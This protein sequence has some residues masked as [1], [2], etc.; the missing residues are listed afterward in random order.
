M[1]TCWNCGATEREGLE[2][3][4]N[5]SRNNHSEAARILGI[6]RTTLLK[7]M[8]RN[9]LLLGLARADRTHLAYRRR[10]EARR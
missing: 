1:K 2:R 10:V 8:K 9:G 4:L 7:A 5:R 6:K 3:A